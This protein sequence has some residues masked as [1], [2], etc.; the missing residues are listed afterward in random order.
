M[1]K[2]HC[3]GCGMSEEVDKALQK[4]GPVTL[5]DSLVQRSWTSDPIF[6]ADLCRECISGILH[7]YF[8]VRAEGEL[9]LPA[10]I[11]PQSIRAVG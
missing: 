1:L 11:E 3:S 8:G 5:T 6:T 7:N 4:I 2:V 10:F 9:E